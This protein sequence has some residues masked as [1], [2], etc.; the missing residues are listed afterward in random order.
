MSLSRGTISTSESISQPIHPLLDAFTVF[1]NYVLLG[2]YSWGTSSPQ[3]ASTLDPG[4]CVRTPASFGLAVA[5]V[6]A[7]P[8][9]VPVPVPVAV[10]RS[11]HSG[12]YIGGRTSSPSRASTASSASS[13]WWG[14]EG[15]SAGSDRASER[16]SG[17]GKVV[18]T[19]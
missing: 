13:A 10:V 2:H 12:R 17:W 16:A 11:R 6:L 3:A 4:L 9:P 15:R 14:R 19:R 1:H 8:V 7:V 18:G 5:L